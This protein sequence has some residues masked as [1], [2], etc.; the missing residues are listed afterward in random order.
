MAKEHQGLV[1]AG[2]VLESNL[3]YSRGRQLVST[4]PMYH[5]F[6]LR[7]YSCTVQ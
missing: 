4:S 7:G 5:P 3:K 6:V 2:S 1:P